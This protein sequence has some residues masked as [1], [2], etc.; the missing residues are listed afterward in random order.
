MMRRQL[1]LE[2]GMYIAGIIAFFVGGPF[3]L[4]YISKMDSGIY[5]PCVLYSLLGI[6]CPGCGG[7]RAM[8]ELLHGH[9]IQSLYYHPLVVY[10]VTIYLVFMISQTISLLSRGRIKGVRFHYWFLY[11]AVVVITLNFILKNLLKFVF[12]IIVF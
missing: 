10:S 1:T 7:T 11:G 9:I 6:Y 3:I 4:F 12:G 8:R 5:P 2:Q